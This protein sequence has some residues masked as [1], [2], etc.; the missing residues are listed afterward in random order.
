[1]VKNTYCRIC[2]DTAAATTSSLSPRIT[3]RSARMVFT[4]STVRARVMTSCFSQRLATVPD[5][6]TMPS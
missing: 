3:V 5:S 4:S 6:V 2:F 1:M